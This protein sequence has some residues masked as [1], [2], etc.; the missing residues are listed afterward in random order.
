[1]HGLSLKS[2]SGPGWKLLESLLS[3]GSPLAKLSTGTHQSKRYNEPLHAYLQSRLL[4]QE[5]FVTKY[6]VCKKKINVR[7]VKLV[8]NHQYDQ[9]DEVKLK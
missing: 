5:L 7:N 2:L 4:C 1:M 8:S 3:D 6:V 9:M